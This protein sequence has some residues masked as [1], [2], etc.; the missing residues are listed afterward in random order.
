MSPLNY[1]TV[2]SV[3]QQGGSIYFALMFI[4]G[5]VY[6]LWPRNRETFQRAAQAALVDEDPHVET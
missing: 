1:E 2:S 5:V 6:A 4:A 3:V